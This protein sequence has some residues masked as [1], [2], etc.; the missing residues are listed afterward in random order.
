MESFEL[1]DILLEFLNENFHQD[2]VR[3][4]RLC[5][6]YVEKIN[7]SGIYTTIDISSLIMTMTYL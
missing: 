7:N 4:I 1:S 5:L 2:K 6:D 3:N